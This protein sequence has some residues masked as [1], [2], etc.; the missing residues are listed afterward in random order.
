MFELES[1]SVNKRY[2]LLDISPESDD[3]FKNLS[4]DS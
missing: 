1:P 4:I 3:Y 2:S